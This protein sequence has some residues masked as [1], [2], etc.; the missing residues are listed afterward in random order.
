MTQSQP[1]LVRVA[2]LCLLCVFVSGARA[3]AG[4]RPNIL[5]ITCEDTSPLLGAYGD[6]LAR[7]PK[8]DA[9]AREA[10]RYTHAFAYTGVCAPSRSCLITGVN[11]ARLGSGGMRSAT[12]LPPEVKCFPEYL[13]AGG[14]YCTNNVKT[15][16]NFAPPGSAWN[17]SS[18]TAHWRQRPAGQPF[19]AVFNLMVTHQSYIF[20]PG[21]GVP[22]AKAAMPPLVTDPARVKLP[23]IHPET[24]EFRQEWARH[25]D[26]VARMDT[27][28]GEILAE[29]AADGLAED[30]IVFFFSDHGTGMP[31][32]KGS[33]WDASLR[34]PLLVRFPKRWQHLAPAAPGAVSDRLVSFVDFAPTILSLGGIPAPASLQGEAFLGRAA[35]APRRYVYGGKD[36]MIERSDSVRYV[37]DGRFQYLR[38]FLPH[39]PHGQF[40]SYNAQHASMRTWQ[41]L[42]E[43]GKLTGA[44]ARF[45]ATKAVEELYDVQA[46]P[47]CLRN[48][49]GEPA[50]VPELERLRA[51]CRDWMLRTGDL[52]LLPEHEV[53]VRSAGTTPWRIATDPK[54]NPLPELLAAAGIANR[55]EAAAV[56]ELKKLLTHA[57]AAIRWWGAVGLVAL[58]ADAAA[59]AGELRVALKDSS[60]SVRIAAAEALGQLGED[61]AALPVLTIALQHESALV[62]LAALNSLDRLGVRARPALDAIRAA[63]LKDPAQRDVADYVQRM[64]SYLP[65]RI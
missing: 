10:V 50:Y 28:A 64:V 52:G 46:D 40:I 48:L 2:V 7:T 5:W 32:I 53:H 63:A 22:K 38:N 33:V 65:D 13:Q 55:R 17:E 37:H 61:D 29:L 45:F 27:Q 56:P 26:N 21:A 47:W 8:L 20:G 30:T 31:S 6:P 62:R 3:A 42:H 25:Y 36:R 58:R 57:D 49:A 23:P 24:P 43:D 14:Y 12:R 51:E 44:P 18:N 11:P 15:D 9:F 4:A 16:Y 60:P 34:V 19:F 39:L 1:A 35:G 59:C 41:R 54:Q